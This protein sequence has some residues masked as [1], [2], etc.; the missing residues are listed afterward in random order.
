MIQ[1]PALALP[2]ELL[3]GEVAGVFLVFARVGAALMIVPGFGEHY[4]LPRLRL[5]LALLLSL[6]LAPV[7]VS[8]GDRLPAEPMALALRLLPEL[9]IGLL[10]GFAARLALAAVHVGGSLIATQSGLA[11]AGM[12]DPNE[13]TPGTLPGTFLT[14]AALAIL[15]AADLHHLVLRAIAASYVLFPLGAGFDPAAAG[16]L[17]LRLVAASLETGARMA[18]PMILA[19]VLINL[20][21]GALGRLVPSLPVMFV[22]L[23]LQLLVDFLILRYSLPAVLHLFDV[24]LAGSLDWLRSGG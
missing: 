7:V 9:G 20:G 10:L 21:M 12:F 18:A 17:V 22:A 5:A 8:T 11:A 14:V 23:P 15:F 24:G 13:A 2:V 16:E 19:G 4:V 1:G 3:A 6:I